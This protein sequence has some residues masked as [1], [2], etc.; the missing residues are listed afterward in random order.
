MPR[1]PACTLLFQPSSFHTSFS[2]ANVLLPAIT[3]LPTSQTLPRKTIDSLTNETIRRRNWEP[4][5]IPTDV[6]NSLWASLYPNTS[7]RAQTD[8]CY[9]VLRN[10]FRWCLVG[11]HPSLVFWVEAGNQRRYQRKVHCCFLQGLEQDSGVKDVVGRWVGHIAM[12]RMVCEEG[13]GEG[14]RSGVGAGAGAG[15]D[16]FTWMRREVEG[17]ERLEGEIVEHHSETRSGRGRIQ[18][19]G[20]DLGAFVEVGV[21]GCEVDGRIGYWLDTPRREHKP[22]LIMAFYGIVLGGVLS[23]VIHRWSF[24]LRQEAKDAINA[25]SAA[26]F[27]KGLKQDSGVKDVVGCWVG[28]ITMRRIV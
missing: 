13:G 4:S 28:R 25:E 6:K 24:G 16:K 2:P 1:Q 23:R 5:V 17:L 10:R 8:T 9:G 11:N 15:K 20:A 21:Q 12:R 27:F 3:H 26:A 7:L 18:S 22:I 14:G 19:V